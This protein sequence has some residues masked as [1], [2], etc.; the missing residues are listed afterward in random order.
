MICINLLVVMPYYDVLVT[1]RVLIR[2]Q[3]VRYCDSQSV[4]EYISHR[5]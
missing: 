2:N 4:R 5:W 1:V 3:E